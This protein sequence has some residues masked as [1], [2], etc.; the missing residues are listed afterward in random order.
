MDSRFSAAWPHDRRVQFALCLFIALLTRAPVFGDP[1]YLPDEQLFF[2][3]GQRM[4]DGFLPYVGV[5]DRKGPGLFL[6]YYLIAGLSRSVVAYQAIAAL[7]AAATGYLVIRLASRFAP[8]AGAIIAGL[9][10]IALLPLFAGGAG[11]APVFYNLPMAAAALLV[12]RGAAQPR[13]DA[14]SQRDE[15]LAMLLAGSAVTFKQTAVFEGIWLGCFALWSAWRQGAGPARLALRALVLALAGAAPMLAFAAAYLAL[16]HFDAFWQAMVISNMRKAYLLGDDQARRLAIFALFLAPTLVPAVLSL[17]LLGRAMGIAR[18]FL[19]GWL[20]AAL[21]GFASVPNFIDH[22]ALPLILPT[23]VAA[24]M[25]LGWRRGTV[26]TGLVVLAVLSAMPLQQ[27]GQRATSRAQ[28]QALVGQIMGRDPAPRLFVFEGPVF[29]YPL[30]GSYP[31]T[32]LIFPLHLFYAP[33]RN[34]SQFDTA[35]EVR[36][37]LAWRPTTIVRAHGLRNDYLNVETDAMV[38]KYL[39][40]RCRRWLTAPLTDRYGTNEYDIYAC[41]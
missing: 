10:Y 3:I 31:P 18:W 26:L 6:V 34:T 36:K 5:W 11:N 33:E 37:V 30:T 8:V 19:I 25:A 24:A 39:Q 32:P 41:V 1:N 21:V 38:R 2:T 29:L 17:T 16:G 12:F 13:N 22:Y 7:F 28:M 27:L 14:R 15:V 35:G 9:L 20:G 40:E 4:H 23:S